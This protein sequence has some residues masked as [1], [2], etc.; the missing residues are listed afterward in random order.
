ELAVPLAPL[1]TLRIGG[2]AEVL[3]TVHTQRALVALLRLTHREGVP[4]HLLG[5]GSNVLYPDAGIEGVVTRLAGVFTRTRMLGERLRAGGAVPLPRL[6]RSTAARG[7]LGL[8]AFSGF[9]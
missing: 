1:T 7:L 5:L 9:P 4:L 6:A 2:A 3:A 8:E